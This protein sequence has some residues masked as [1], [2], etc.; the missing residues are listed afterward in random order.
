M[1][2]IKI[3]CKNIIS[4]IIEIPEQ[5]MQY[6]ES[7]GQIPSELEAQLIEEID[8]FFDWGI[9]SFDT[10][11]DEVE[12]TAAAAAESSLHKPIDLTGQSFTT[13]SKTTDFSILNQ[14]LGTNEKVMAK[15]E[16]F[17]EAHLSK[18]VEIT[19][20]ELI[21]C[22]RYLPS[23]LD[24][25]IATSIFDYPDWKIYDFYRHEEYYL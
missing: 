8:E 2:K 21:D 16:I 1:P 10:H 12:V 13:N 3:F 7:I 20:E 9:N 17:A 14:F 15:I 24:E 11:V 19:E 5:T 4:Q 18:I 25:K 23:D 6:C 22:T